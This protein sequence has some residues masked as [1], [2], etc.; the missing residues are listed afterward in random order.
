M[1][2]ISI[3]ILSL[4]LSSLCVKAQVVYEM[5]IPERQPSSSTFPPTTTYPPTNP[6]YNRIQPPPQVQTETLQTTAYYQTTDGNYHKTRIKVIIESS[7]YAS[8]AYVVAE[9]KTTRLG[10]S[11]VNIGSRASVQ[12]CMPAA[13]YGGTSLFEQAYVYKALVNMN[14]YYFDL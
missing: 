8:A 10:G 13:A 3:I 5:F 2:Q 11:W 1:K 7:Q 12:Q 9:Y 6:S 14:W 4:L